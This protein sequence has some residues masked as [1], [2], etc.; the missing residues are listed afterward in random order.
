MT[1]PR[2]LLLLTK[3]IIVVNN[4]TTAGFQ[5]NKSDNTSGTL[6]NVTND[7]DSSTTDRIYF[8]DSAAESVSN[9]PTDF[10]RTSINLSLCFFDD[11]IFPERINSNDKDFFPIYN[12]KKNRIDINTTVDIFCQVPRDPCPEE[13]KSALESSEE[14]FKLFSDGTLQRTGPRRDS[15]ETNNFCID[16]V[17]NQWK[18]IIC[19][20]LKKS[21]VDLIRAVCMLISV[22]FFV[23]TFLVYALIENLRNTHGRTLCAYILCLIVGYCTIGSGHLIN[24]GEFTGLS[25]C[26]LGIFFLYFM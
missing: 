25:C 8:L 19:V 18:V 21:T 9:R 12:P 15:K 16:K 20:P 1:T 11:G 26:L 13:I 14:S 6:Q 10:C 7:F 17:E 22:P 24:R 3:L 23:A 4:Y 2:V 5:P